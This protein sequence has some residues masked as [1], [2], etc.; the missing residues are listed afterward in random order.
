M[1]LVRLVGW[2]Q[3]EPDW[4]LMLRH[5]EGLG[6]RLPDGRLVA[7][8]VALRFRPRAGW[9]SM[10]IVDPDYRGLG[11]ARHLLQ[12]AL[13]GLDAD[14]YLAALDA[15]PAGLGVY[16]KLGFAAFAQI[17]RW[18]GIGEGVDKG[19]RAVST[20]ASDNVAKAPIRDAMG[21]DCYSA[22]AQ[23][24]RRGWSWS[25]D[26]EQ[27]YA[28][29]RPG[30][31]ATHL[32]PLIAPS[33]VCAIDLCALA[34]DD[35]HGPVVLDVPD[36]QTELSALLAKRGFVRERGFHRMGRGPAGEFYLHPSLRVTAGPEL[37]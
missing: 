11:L 1:E 20:L 7:T 33:T 6:V 14:G 28:W 30:R 27:A 12:I 4:E 19:P 2:N 35:L 17:S 25:L 32:G 8:T 13:K 29:A 9:I 21:H 34:L 16:E 15:T 22:L 37:G 26:L 24:A 23:I 18:R 5:G 3:T 36:E 31:T 10:V